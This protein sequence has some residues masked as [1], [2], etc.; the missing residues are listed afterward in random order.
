MKS[1]AATPSAVFAHSLITAFAEIQGFAALRT[2]RVLLFSRRDRGQR[3]VV[4]CRDRLIGCRKLDTFSHD[5][6]TGKAL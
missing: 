3:P 5:I 1:A 6:C 2:G 4:E